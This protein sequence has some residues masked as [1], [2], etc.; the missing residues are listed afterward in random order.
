VEVVIDRC[1]I[2]SMDEA[3][4]RTDSNSSTV[5]MT[6]TRYSDIGEALFIGVASGN[7]T[8]SNNTEY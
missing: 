4:F 7:I 6:N 5:T 8:Q 3:I 1:D 2:S